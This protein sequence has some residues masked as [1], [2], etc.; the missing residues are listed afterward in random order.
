VYL[1]I[2]INILN[3]E[4]YTLNKS[5]VIAA[6]LATVAADGAALGAACDTVTTPENGGCSAE[7]RCAT[8][9]AVVLNTCVA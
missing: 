5:S 7:L 1:R 9:P 8:A 4:M 2:I 3:L 6:L